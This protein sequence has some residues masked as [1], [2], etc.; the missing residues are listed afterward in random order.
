VSGKGEVRFLTTGLSW[1]TS[2]SIATYLIPLFVGS[3]VAAFHWRYI[4]MALESNIDLIFYLSLAPLVWMF[5]RKDVPVAEKSAFGILL[6]A[7]VFKNTI[8]QWVIK[9]C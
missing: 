2:H 4:Q 7:C 3:R 1:A 9:M 8:F 5:N 6:S